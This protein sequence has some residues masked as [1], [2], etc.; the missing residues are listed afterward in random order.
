VG[1]ADFVSICN[2][3][4]AITVRICRNCMNG[5]LGH[6]THCDLQLAELIRNWTAG[7]QGSYVSS[8]LSESSEYR[9]FGLIIILSSIQCNRVLHNHASISVLQSNC[10]HLF[11]SG[12]LIYAY[13]LIIRQSRS[14]RPLERKHRC[15]LW[16]SLTEVIWRLQC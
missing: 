14:L 15:S 11:A 9:K 6:I 10:D 16:S 1:L 13:S 2:K 8:G 4:L 5:A 7:L 12:L 3:K